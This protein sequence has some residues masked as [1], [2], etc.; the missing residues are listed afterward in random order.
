MSNL[1]LHHNGVYNLYSSVSDGPYYDS[2]LTLE[3]LKEQTK[4]FYGCEGLSDL[5]ARLK[6]AHK[7]G[8]SSIHGDTLQEC[9]ESNSEGLSTDEF[10]AQYLTIKE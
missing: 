2:G 5:P 9:V 10:I 4:F 3:R 1:I 6:R 7:T 8:C